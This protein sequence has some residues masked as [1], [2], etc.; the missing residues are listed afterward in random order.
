[1]TVAEVVTNPAVPI[2]PAHAR[3]VR[4]DALQHATATVAPLALIQI[5][6]ATIQH[7]LAKH[8]ST[9]QASE[10]SIIEMEHRADLSGHK[11]HPEPA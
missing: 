10:S 11:R 7:A 5:A 6:T 2:K 8:Q 4:V 1:V 9:A 3:Q